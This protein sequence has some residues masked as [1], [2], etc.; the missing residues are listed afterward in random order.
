VQKPEDE[1]QLR[2]LAKLRIDGTHEYDKEAQNFMRV[3]E[4]FGGKSEIISLSQAH[5]GVGETY[6]R[7]PKV[8]SR[9]TS[10]QAQG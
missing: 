2:E 9:A 8:K 3:A 7:F 5:T 1:G 10:P 6:L 4:K